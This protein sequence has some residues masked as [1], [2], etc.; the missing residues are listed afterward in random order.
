[1]VCLEPDILEPKVKWALGSI[2]TNK[3]SG[4]D[5][6]PTELFLI[7]KMMPCHVRDIVQETGI[8]T[9]PSLGRPYK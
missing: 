8:K 4:G 1:M 9:I 6:I 2:N 5:R 3:V 7:L